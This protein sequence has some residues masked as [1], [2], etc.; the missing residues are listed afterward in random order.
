L[1]GSTTGTIGAAPEAE[2]KVMRISNT[3]LS[4]DS[5]HKLFLERPEFN[6]VKVNRGGRALNRFTVYHDA[7]IGVELN[8]FI[9]AI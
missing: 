6:T 4:S 1:S 7:F 9:G 2:F 3:E 8:E 5:S